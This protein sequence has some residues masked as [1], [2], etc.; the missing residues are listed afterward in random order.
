MVIKLYN[1]SYSS[2]QRHGYTYKDKLYGCQ[3]SYYLRYIKQI[4]PT[5]TD[6]KY[7]I[8][9]KIIHNILADFYQSVNMGNINDY[10]NYKSYFD[11]V[12]VD[13]LSRKWDY[14]LP[15]KT[16]Q[17]AIIILT[18]FSINESNKYTAYMNG[19]TQFMPLYVE[20]SLFE[21]FNIRIDR[22]NFDHSFTDFKTSKEMPDSPQIEHIL[23][24]GTYAISYFKKYGIW[25]P[26]MVYYFLRHNK[27]LV[28]PITQEVI[29]ITKIIA[30][31]VTD[32]IN[33]DTFIKN[34]NNCEWCDM[35]HV[36]GLEVVRLI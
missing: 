3:W 8:F 5:K 12:L 22:V 27:A 7:A 31:N 1:L 35:R 30:N 16:Y 21:P 17:D 14:V 36:C 23:Q 29:D 19:E 26:K 18:N 34:S 20:I 9:G 11:K 33:K 10:P 15:E 6:Q 28:V 32:N 13:L 25:S 4:Y 24:A 2:I